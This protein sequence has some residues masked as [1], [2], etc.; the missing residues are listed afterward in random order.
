MLGC[1]WETLPHNSQ[2]ERNKGGVACVDPTSLPDS[3]VWGGNSQGLGQNPESMPNAHIH[4]SYN[5]GLGGQTLSVNG[6][7]LALSPVVRG[8]P[9]VILCLH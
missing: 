1:S 2:V 6:H 4:R 9:L 5:H 3:Q 8:C 7:H